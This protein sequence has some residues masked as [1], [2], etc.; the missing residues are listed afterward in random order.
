MPRR[1]VLRRV[2]QA[3]SAWHA[4]DV[5]GAVRRDLVPLRQHAV[6]DGAGADVAAASAPRLPVRS[7]VVPCPVSGQFHAS[8]APTNARADV[9]ASAPRCESLAAIRASETDSGLASAV[10]ADFRRSFFQQAGRVARTACE[11]K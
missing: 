6:R 11:A 10:D 1:T 8:Q 5:D 9:L 7:R 3:P 4:T 2:Q